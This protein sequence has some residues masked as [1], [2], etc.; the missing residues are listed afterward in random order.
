MRTE[1]GLIAS[2]P[3]GQLGVSFLAGFCPLRS[4]NSRVWDPELS[5]PGSRVNR[6]RCTSFFNGFKRF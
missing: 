3:Q 6:P 2:R 4:G 1:H 5:V